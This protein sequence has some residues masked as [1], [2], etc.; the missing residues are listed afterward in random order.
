MLLTSRPNSCPARDPSARA[1]A[2]FSIFSRAS[3]RFLVLFSDAVMRDVRVLWLL[4]TF[5]RS[6]MSL[7]S[8]VE[9]SRARASLSWL[10]VPSM[11]LIWRKT[12]SMSC[13]CPL[14]PPSMALRR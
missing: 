13:L 5:A 9:A 1:L 10:V 4:S 3:I 11:L 8:T 6:W 2:V 7:L 12:L 14:N